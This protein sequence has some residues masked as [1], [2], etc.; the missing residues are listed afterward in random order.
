MQKENVVLQPCTDL[1][2]YQPPQSETPVN[3]ELNFDILEFL[4]DAQDDEQLA[5]TQ[6]EKNAE[7]CETVTTKS[8]VA[9]KTSQ[10]CHYKAPFLDAKLETLE[11]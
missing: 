2:L 10:N 7:K 11:L 6:V 4:A 9:K 1:Q 5:A 3:Y 8:V